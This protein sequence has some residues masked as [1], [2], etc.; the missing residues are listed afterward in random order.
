ME[1]LFDAACRDDLQE[2]QR[3]VTI[4]FGQDWEDHVRGPGRQGNRETLLHAACEAGAT[5]VSQFLLPYFQ[6]FVDVREEE[7]IGGY[8]AL[9][10]AVCSDHMNIVSLLLDHGAD[11]NLTETLSGFSALHL[12]VRNKNVNM[13]KLLV[14]RGAD[15]HQRDRYGNNPL[16]WGK[17]LGLGEQMENAMNLYQNKAILPMS[18]TIEERY[19]SAL[20]NKSKK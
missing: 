19:T 15:V 7:K 20:Y 5:Q 2:L 4:V 6:S 11:P 9:M 13:V 8:T 14:A 10:K 12:A 1:L 17:D 18:A 16:W 3:L